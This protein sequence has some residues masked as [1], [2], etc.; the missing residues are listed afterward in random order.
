MKTFMSLCR[1]ICG[2]LLLMGT[3]AMA[4]CQETESSLLP[5]DS[6]DQSLSMDAVYDRPFLAGQNSNVAIGG[7]LE[8]NTLYQSTDGVSEG[9]SFQARR[10][11]VFLS[12]SIA[13]SI[14]FLSE[15]ELEDGG[16]ELA[17]EFAA[18]DIALH[19][20]VNLR[21]GIIMNPIGSFNQNHD[22]PKW[23]FVDRPEV[24]VN[25]LPATWSN[26]GF[27]IYG[28]AFKKEWILGYEVYLSNGFDD[29]IIDNEEN[30]TFLPATKESTGRFE[31]SSNG[32]P[33]LTAKTALRHKKFGEIGLSYMGGV[34][35]TFRPDG[36]IVDKKRNTHTFAIDWSLNIHN[37]NT[38]ILGELV[39]VQVDVPDTYTQQFGEHQRGLFLDIIQPVFKGRILQWPEATVNVATRLD[40]VDWNVGSFRENQTNIGESIWAITPAISFRPT[41]QA[42]IRLNYRYHWLRDIINNPPSKTGAWLFGISA[43]F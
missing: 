4:L 35:N 26:A 1:N 16:K 42:V 24:A 9:L 41:S 40:Y 20:A 17:I 27:G 34:Y 19:P 18:L 28:K 12:A 29:R 11:T 36:L 25:L 8:A 22:G 43:Y 30:K 3:F 38:T 2:F 5:T 32:K 23:E 14:T 33:L 6:A 15:V 37:T 31:H 13:R 39:F 10:L 7:Y 21:G